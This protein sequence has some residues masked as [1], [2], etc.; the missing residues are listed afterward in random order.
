MPE[1]AS[2]V[3]Q[4][5]P[6]TDRTTPTPPAPTGKPSLADLA[7]LPPTVK[8]ETAARLMGIGRS[9]AYELV[10]RDEFPCT[11]LHVGNRYIIPTASLLRVLDINPEPASRKAAQ[12]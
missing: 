1:P 3:P 9:L 8:V 12:P 4:P 2:R 6:D 7:G 11:V 10:R 5:R